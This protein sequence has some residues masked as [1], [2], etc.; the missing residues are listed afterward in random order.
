[1]TSGVYDDVAFFRVLD[2]FVAQFGIS[3]DPDTAARWRGKRI[4]DDPA[5]RSNTAGTISYAMA[6][7]HTR[8]TQLFINLADNARLDAMGFAPFAELTAGF[9]V[10]ES[11][12]GGYGEG[13]PRGRGPDQGLIQSEGNAYLREKFPKLD[14]VTKA[15]IVP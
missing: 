5:V 1:V 9:D 15:T 14:Y 10:V 3:G 12:Y 8:T 4:T 13:A 7:P 2:G 11:L 6:G